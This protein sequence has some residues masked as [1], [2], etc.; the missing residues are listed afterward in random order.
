[1]K[2]KIITILLLISISSLSL[3]GI[4]VIY[5]IKGSSINEGQLTQFSALA[6]ENNK[7]LAI[8]K[9]AKL[10]KS[11]PQAT[12]INGKGHALL[13][14][15]HDAHAHVMALSRLQ[16][17]VDLSGITSLDDSLKKVKDFAE[18]H[19]DAEWILGRGWNQVLWKGKQ[20]PNKNDLDKLNIDRPI[21]LKR[22]DGHAAWGNSIAMQ[23]AGTTGI[24]KDIDG[25]EIIVDKMGVQTGIFVD[26][27]M[28]LIQ[29]HVPQESP[30]DTIDTMLRGLSYLAS[31]GLTSVDDAGIE[32]QTYNAYKL[33]AKNKLM[34]IRINAMVASGDKN[35]AKMLKKPIHDENGFL[36]VH[37]IKYVFDGALGSRGAAMLAPY[38][39][40][41]DT[42]GLIVQPQEFIEKIMYAHAPQ[43]WQTAIHSIGD[44]AN[45]MALMLMADQRALTK[46]NRNRV[47]HAQV[48]N[49]D[50]L[51]LF[52]KHQI[53][54]S[55]QPTHA[56][57]DKNMAED[58]I[59][60]ERLKG[61]Y[62]WQT[63]IK[64]GA[65][66]ASGSDFPI[67]LPNP[68][69]GLH[70]AVTRQDRNNQPKG[71]WIPSE[72]MTLEQALASF[73]INAA[74]AN[75]RENELGSLET[76]KLADF[77]LVDQDIFA[78]KPEDIWKTTVLQTWVNGKKVYEKN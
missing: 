76:G 78:I 32:F 13:P 53:I 66:I 52:K 9:S 74:Y 12:F 24:E 73:T 23:I 34:P 10:K 77:I 71:G 58:R 46:V 72:K 28:D 44:R 42:L 65:L 60:K 27:A 33:L 14:G 57:S 31:L 37:A 55:M 54:A 19:P 1:M 30:F 70:A 49:V 21:W 5:N 15:L 20:F 62:A 16:N 38:S 64:D 29:K 59:G 69:Y 3:A 39:D 61:A 51:H 7:V 68:F 45:R 75:R 6:F 48:V 40:R 63:L 50:D 35:L 36:Q 25:G 43:G 26:N 67:E 4:T 2:C 8:G 41:H 47:E 17:Q 22:I 56:T 18:T 11:Y